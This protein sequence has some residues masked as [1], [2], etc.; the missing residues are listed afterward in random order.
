MGED[1]RQRIY[2]KWMALR[3]LHS[4]TIA[5]CIE[6]RRLV[7]RRHF[8]GTASLN[9]GRVPRLVIPP[10][11]EVRTHEAGMHPAPR[12]LARM[13]RLS[14]SILQVILRHQSSTSFQ[15]RPVGVRTWTA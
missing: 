14:V 12:Y 10:H 11:V 4:G 13:Q 3:G 2:D 8:V 6:V 7:C 15:T 1:D 9:A 5:W